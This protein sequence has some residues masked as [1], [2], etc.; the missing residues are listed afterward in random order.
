[1][2]VLTRKIG[3]TIMIGDHIEV[4]VLQI[5]GD[6]VKIGVNAPKVIEIYRKEV[7]NQ[8]Q[9]INQES[10]RNSVDILKLNQIVK[11]KRSSSQED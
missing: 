9:Q 7:Y 2:L 8:I 11:D 4:T 10:S 5:E 1:M 3:E 6:A